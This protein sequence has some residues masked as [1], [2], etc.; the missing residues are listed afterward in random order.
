M[1]SFIRPGEG[2]PRDLPVWGH[3]EGLR[4]GL[5]P[6][7]GPR[8]L[9][10]IYAPYLG[11]PFPRMVNYIAIEPR[12]EGDRHRGL[13][14]LEMSRQDSG[15]R[16]LCFVA[17]DRLDSFE[18]EA[19]PAPGE[20]DGDR[21]HLFVHS[22]RFHNGARPIVE[23]ILHRD[24]PFE[25]DLV[26]HAASDSADML[27]CVLTATMANYGQ[28]R[29]LHLADGHVVS[30]GELW[31]GEEPNDVGFLPFR[32]WPASDLELTDQGERHVHLTTDS[33]NPA[34]ETY[35]DDVAPHWRYAGRS[36]SHHWSARDVGGLEVA[37]NGRRTYWMSQSPIPG[38]IAFENFELRAP[39]QSGQRF[40]FG[41]YPDE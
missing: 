7:S 36:A 21:L 40:C 26:T 30:A 25:L 9:L 20:I 32:T 39:F 4:V 33:E 19:P 5:A 2:S 15:E 41:V 24:R 11:Q 10:R 22:E 18:A 38:G 14:E 29:L 27:N 8:G 17:S 23:C 12:V 35:P 31:A 34:A 13:S 6:T 1:S 28:L 16:G 3:T 37:V